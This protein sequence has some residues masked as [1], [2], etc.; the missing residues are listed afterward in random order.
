MEV[1]TPVIQRNRFGD[2]DDRVRS[3]LSGV[4]ELPAEVAIRMPMAQRLERLR[5]AC[6]AEGDGF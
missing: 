5:G 3:R 2:P 4:L 1:A 6:A